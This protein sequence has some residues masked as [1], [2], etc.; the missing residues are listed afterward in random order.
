MKNALVILFSVSAFFA[1]AQS[2]IVKDSTYTITVNGKFSQAHYIEYEDGSTSLTVSP[3]L[4]ADETYTAKLQE[5]ES[6]AGTMANDVRHVSG[7]SKRLTELKRQNDAIKTLTGKSP[8]DTIQSRQIFDYLVAGWSIKE[9]GAVA[10][11]VVFTVTAGGQMRYKIGS[12]AVKNVTLFGDAMRL[13]NYGTGIDADLFK[14]QNGN[15][16]DAIRRVILRKPGSVQQ[17]P[18]KKKK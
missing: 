14:L 3:G 11:D 15:F 12:D 18:L 17:S 5:F 4:T 2:A 16:V 1:H 7:F 10:R 8:L 13:N 6:A 9:N